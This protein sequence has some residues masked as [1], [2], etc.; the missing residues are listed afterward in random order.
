MFMSYQDQMIF[1]TREES[2]MEEPVE[3]VERQQC[4]ED[5]GY[6]VCNFVFRD[7]VP[8]Y[9]K[10]RKWWKFPTHR[11]Y[12]KRTKKGKETENKARQRPVS[13]VTSKKS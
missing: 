1:E 8:R 11:K 13:K 12:K 5:N 6:M 9:T 2:A 4:F 7:G 10:S 3:I